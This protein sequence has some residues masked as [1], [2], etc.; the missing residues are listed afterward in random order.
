[1]STKG[2]SSS[3]G[4]VSSKT[5]EEVALLQ[6]II[7][8]ASQKTQHCGFA[9]LLAGL[10]DMSFMSEVPELLEGPLVAEKGPHQ[11]V[12][13]RRE[14]T[15]KTVGFSGT[16]QQCPFG[17]RFRVT[18]PSWTVVYLREVEDIGFMVKHQSRAALVVPINIVG[19]VTWEKDKCY[20]LF[21]P[22]SQAI[23]SV[24]LT[25]RTDG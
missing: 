15:G 8:P 21:F 4:Q 9:G 7:S 1:M 17:V 18:C 16:V 3:P 13:V 24:F 14:Q 11:P 12:P 22:R 25:N 5:I 2:C 6:F 10:R 19:T 20:S 23:L